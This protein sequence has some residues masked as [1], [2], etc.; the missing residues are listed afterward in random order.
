MEKHYGEGSG[1]GKRVLN[2][3]TVVHLDEDSYLEMETVQ[4]EGVDNTKRVTK[5]I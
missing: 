1:S 4:I 5:A 2:P 3:V